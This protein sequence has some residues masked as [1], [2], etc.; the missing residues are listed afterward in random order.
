MRNVAEVK[1]NGKDLGVVWTVPWQMEITNVVKPGDNRPPR[2]IGTSASPLMQKLD[3]KHHHTLL[4][5]HF[6]VDEM[7][8]HHLR[9]LRVFETLAFHHMAPVAR[10]ITD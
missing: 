10:R 4:A 3:G 8:V 9:H 6:H 1:L 7:A 2:S 5:V